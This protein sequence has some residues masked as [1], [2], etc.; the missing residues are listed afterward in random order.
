ML[1]LIELLQQGGEVPAGTYQK[2][3]NNGMIPASID[4]SQRIYKRYI[5]HLHAFIA[6]GITNP[7]MTAVTL[8]SE[9]FKVSDRTVYRSIKTI[10]EI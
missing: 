3:L 8:T 10:E 6:M 4:S 5:Q 9:E 1:D 7:Q 2:M